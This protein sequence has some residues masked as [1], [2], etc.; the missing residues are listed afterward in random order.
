MIV[1]CPIWLY[2][3]SFILCS[4]SSIII[5]ICIERKRKV[6]KWI[7]EIDR[8]SKYWLEKVKEG[9]KKDP[10]LFRPNEIT[11]KVKE[12]T[13]SLDEDEKE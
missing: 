5:A 6:E 2:L 10:S 8:F 3:L 4:V 7:F 1:N 13:L 9:I 12:F 11:I